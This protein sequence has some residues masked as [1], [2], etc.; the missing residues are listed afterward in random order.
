MS[1]YRKKG[2]EGSKEGRRDFHL[3]QHIS[4]SGLLF[5]GLFTMLD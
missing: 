3:T 2:K 4:R 1:A 5:A